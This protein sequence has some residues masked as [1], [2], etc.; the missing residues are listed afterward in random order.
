MKSYEQIYIFQQPSYKEISPMC[1]GTFPYL[2][3]SYIPTLYTTYLSAYLLYQCCRFIHLPLP[4]T[5]I[6]YVGSRK[7]TKLYFMRVV[8]C[9]SCFAKAS[10]SSNGE[11]E[12]VESTGGV[13]ETCCLPELT[14][15]CASV[16]AST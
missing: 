10:S 3:T 16:S 8:C 2:N 12:Q 1:V 6:L 15:W 14:A 4:P 13:R 11:V 9:S 7:S 5:T